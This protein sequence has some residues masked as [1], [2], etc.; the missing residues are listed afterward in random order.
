MKNLIFKKIEAKLKNVLESDHIDWIQVGRVLSEVKEHNYWSIN[1]GSFSKWLE[2]WGKEIN[3]CKATLWR[4]ITAQKKYE[5]LRA[6]ASKFGYDF[7]AIEDLKC[8]I[9]PE[10]IEIF[11]KL[12]R[13]LKE[14]EVYEM[15][16][17]FI[18]GEITR[19]ELREKWNV[20]KP[21]LEQKASHGLFGESIVLDALRL[22]SNEWLRKD[23]AEY[24]KGKVIYR[25]PSFSKFFQSVTV[26]N[27]IHNQHYVLD[28][29]LA[30]QEMSNEPLH[31]HGV[32]IVSQNLLEY[33]RFEAYRKYCNALWIAAPRGVAEDINVKIPQGIG[34]I[35]V[36]NK[37]IEVIITAEVNHSPEFLVETCKA[38]LTRW[39]TA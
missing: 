31:I 7:E 15:M 21:A 16:N 18:D 36:N 11:D 29:I 1:F 28:A 5:R 12:S 2:S 8:P 39:K 19:K 26:T 14:N 24:K 6:E 25:V 17:R 34:L 9:S 30:L 38:L 33:E 37:E 10:G 23:K 32:A 3:L 13:I 20:F 22:N 35:S 4:Y 27:S